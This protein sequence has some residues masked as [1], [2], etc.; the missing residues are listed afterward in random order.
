MENKEKK[1][2]TMLRKYADKR[3]RINCAKALD[4]A[5]SLDVAPSIVGNLATQLDFKIENCLLA[6]FGALKIGK[7]NNTI[8]K[9][10]KQH[11]DEKNR[12]RCF[13]A[14][15]VAEQYSAY[16]VR[17]TIRNSELDVIYCQLGCFREKKRPR[18]KIK[19]KIWI[20]NKD[21]GMVFGKG[22]LEILELINKKGSISAA[23]KDLGVSYKKVW[24]H[25]QILE[26]N[27]N[28]QYVI[29]S[30]G[31]RVGGSII[32]QD[33]KNFMEKFK[34]LQ[35]DIEEYANTRFMEL[36]YQDRTFERKRR[37]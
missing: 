37:F 33:A 19:T 14:M 15:K 17:S 26:N 27:M 6:Q 23:A 13:Y 5:K 22:K 28:K 32:T 2:K 8:Y 30:K 36:F 24:N 11:A 34:K 16:K 21:I 29:T 31:R 1:I 12:I 10:L 9:K 25:I 7:L 20:E 18:L 4:I 3:G 35:K